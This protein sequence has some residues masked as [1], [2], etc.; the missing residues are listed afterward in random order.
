MVVGGINETTAASVIGADILVAGTFLFQH[1]ESFSK[2]VHQLQA[3]SIVA[4]KT[5]GIV[6]TPQ[7]FH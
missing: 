5:F 3:A 2:G 7:N 4:G 1:P 6:N